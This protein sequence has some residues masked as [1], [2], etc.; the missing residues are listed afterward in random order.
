MFDTLLLQEQFFLSINLDNYKFEL[1]KFLSNIPGSV[2]I[3][4]LKKENEEGGFVFKIGIIMCFK[5]IS[6]NILTKETQTSNISNV[7][8]CIRNCYSKKN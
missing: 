3:V 1:E 6:S 7:S 4:L 5:I 8:V 2:K